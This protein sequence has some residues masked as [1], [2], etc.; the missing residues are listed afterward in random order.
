M[1]TR[2]KDFVVF[3]IIFTFTPSISW[4]WGPEIHYF[5]GSRLLELGVVGGSL[6]GLITRHSDHFLYGN[7]IADLVV[8]KGFL[9]GEDHSHH[10]SIDNRLQ[11]AVRNDLERSFAMGVRCHLAADTVAH[12]IFVPEWNGRVFPSTK[13]GH[14]YWEMRAG[15]YV[16]LTYK[17]ELDSLMEKNFEQEQKLFETVHKKTLLPF[18]V[19]WVITN[20]LVNLFSHSWW[21]E[22]S[23][24]WS[25][26]SRFDLGQ[27]IDEYFAQS[28][29]RMRKALGTS[30][31]QESI[32]NIDPM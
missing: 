27:E 15:K 6:G 19:N 22:I 13:P 2:F 4:A 11:N 21:H 24:R 10:W 26:L 20:R 1:S 23:E 9:D 31:E 7:V 29:E 17:E 32:R 3:C 8:G 14:V 28:L 16:P 25:R 18:P 12:N 5:L 30:R